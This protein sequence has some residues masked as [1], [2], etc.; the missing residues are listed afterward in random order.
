MAAGA[1]AGLSLGGMI[2]LSVLCASASYIA[3]TAAASHALPEAN[4]ALY[5]GAS[6]GVTFPFNILIGVPL[7]TELAVRW[8]PG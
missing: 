7:I 8:M 4:P 3:A 5:L 1:A 2:L 6:L